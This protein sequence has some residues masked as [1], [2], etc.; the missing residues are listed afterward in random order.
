MYKFLVALISLTA[1]S[2]YADVPA[3]QQVSTAAVQG[4]RF[5][6]IESP[7]SAR[8]VFRL[9]RY[10][11]ETCVLSVTKTGVPICTKIPRADEAMKPPAD[12]A[13][14]QVF[15]SG[16]AVRNTYLLN[17]YSGVT[18]MLVNTATGEAVWDVVKPM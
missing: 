7:V 9:D 1:C 15:T 2:V 6:I 8:F 10:S 4:A 5:Q 12:R 11:G 16:T 13:W 3:P 14:F 17:V 18:W